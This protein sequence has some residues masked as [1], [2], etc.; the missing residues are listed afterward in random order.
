MIR[1]LEITNSE[2]VFKKIR[3]IVYK[4]SKCII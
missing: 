3:I 1:F 2:F 4:C